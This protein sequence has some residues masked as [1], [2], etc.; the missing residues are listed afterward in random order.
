L[1]DRPHNDHEC[2]DAATDEVIAMV[3]ARDPSLVEVAEQFGN[4]DAAAAWLRTLPQRDDHGAPADGPKVAACRPPQRLRFDAFDPNCFERAARWIGVAE[5]LDPD[6]TY[7]LA[8]VETPSGLHTFPTRDG[9]P[10]ILDPMQSRNALRAGLYRACR[11]AGPVVLTPTQAID[12]LAGLAMEPAERFRSG[13]HRVRCAHRAL[14]AVLVMRPLCIADVRDVAFLLALAEREA[15]LYGPMG[16]RVVH[17]TARAIDQLDRLA[18]D[19]W[20]ATQGGERNA[21]PFELRIGDYKISPDIPLL[22]SLARIGGRIAGNVGLE[23]L[24]V[25]LATMGITPPILN[26]LEGEL[27]REGL[28][29]GPLAAPPP[30]LGSFA[31]M[32]PEALAGRWLAQKL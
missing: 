7:R 25:K 6:H 28:S 17:S 20:L 19:R 26:S 10:V 3:Q 22:G 1:I 2:L 4:A 24:K 18:A 5:L 31:A 12:W 23:A 21:G 15:R 29:L 9:A 11:N 27:K 30:M 13:P 16:L 32:T 8:T 14:R